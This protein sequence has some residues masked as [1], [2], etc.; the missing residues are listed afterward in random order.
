MVM[1]D[2]CRRVDASHVE[3]NLIAF[4][5]DE[6]LKSVQYLWNLTSGDKLSK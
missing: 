4:L 6:A 1:V 3:H 2:I 5:R